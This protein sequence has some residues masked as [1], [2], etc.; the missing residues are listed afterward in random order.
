LRAGRTS[1]LIS[2]RLATLRDAGISYVLDGGRILERGTHAELLAARGTYARLFE[3]Q[4]SGYR[5]GPEDG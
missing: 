1:L 3:L 5:D 4:A 2:H